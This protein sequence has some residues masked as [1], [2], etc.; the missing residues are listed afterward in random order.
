MSQTE[1]I[2]KRIQGL[3]E[4]RNM[5]QRELASKVGITE[6]SIGRYVKDSREPKG[7]VLADI[8]DALDSTTDYLLGRTDDPNGEED[9]VTIAAHHDGDEFSDEEKEMIEKFKDM[10]REM[11]K[12]KR[13]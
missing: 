11:K 7:R 13:S 3:L 10:V 5:T 9:I 6:V 2:G 12:K 1:S 4:L 8:A